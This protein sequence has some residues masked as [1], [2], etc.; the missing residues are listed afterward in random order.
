MDSGAS[1]LF[2][3]YFPFFLPAYLSTIHTSS[4]ILLYRELS[5]SFPLFPLFS[6]ELL[7]FDSDSQGRVAYIREMK[8]VAYQQLTLITSMETL[9]KDSDD[10]DALTLLVVGTEA[11]QI[12]ILPQVQSRNPATPAILATHTTLTSIAR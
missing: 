9:K 8:H 11:G 7:S 1:I 2:S 10:V 4:C 3:V 6:S 12:L 5:P